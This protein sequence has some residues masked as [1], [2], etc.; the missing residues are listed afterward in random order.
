MNDARCT[1]RWDLVDAVSRRGNA[2]VGGLQRAS[3]RM[4][5]GRSAHTEWQTERRDEHYE[6]E[7]KI[8]CEIEVSGWRCT[9]GGRADGVD[10]AGSHVVVEEIK[11]SLMDGFSL[12]GTTQE[13]WPSACAQLAIYVWMLSR[14][15]KSVCRVAWCW[16]RF[17]ME[18]GT[19]SLPGRVKVV[20]RVRQ[21]IERWVLR[22]ATRMEWMAL[23][24]HEVVVPPFEA[25]RPGQRNRRVGR[26]EPLREPACAG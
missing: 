2:A 3:T 11:S 19:R 22:R 14:R 26:V 6:A 17:W 13:D 21:R 25:W 8:S 4:E 7:Q 24:K 18:P 12:V 16:C 1:S 23:R 15:A 10:R 5:Q 20:E 9:V